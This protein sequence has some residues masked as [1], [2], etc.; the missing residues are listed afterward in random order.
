MSPKDAQAAGVKDGDIVSVK[1]DPSIT[2]VPIIRLVLQP[3][4]ENAIY[5]GL[6]YKDSKGPV[7]YTHLHY[8]LNHAKELSSLQNLQKFYA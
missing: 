5:H 2:Q 4:V 3:L 6:K 8:G 7:S 1:A